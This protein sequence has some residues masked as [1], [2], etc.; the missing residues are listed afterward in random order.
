MARR[1]WKSRWRSNPHGSSS[2][3]TGSHFRWRLILIRGVRVLSARVAS[4]VLVR[5]ARD[6]SR[7]RRDWPGARHSLRVLLGHRGLSHSLLFAPVLAA[8]LVDADLPTDVRE[9]LTLP[10]V[11]VLLPG[12][13][14]PRRARRV[15]QRRPRQ[16]ILRAVR[17]HPLVPTLGPVVV[18]RSGSVPSSPNGASVSSKPSCCRSGFLRSCSRPHRGREKAHTLNATSHVGWASPKFRFKSRLTPIIAEA[19]PARPGGTVADV[20]PLHAHIPPAGLAGGRKPKPVGGRAASRSAIDFV[21]T[22]PR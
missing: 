5:G 8:A 19:Y 11:A 3:S 1:S 16:R 20:C 12:Q 10:R 9:R 17:G 4:A 22:E 7:R 14:L 21:C 18:S 15:D 13:G 2:G 6:C